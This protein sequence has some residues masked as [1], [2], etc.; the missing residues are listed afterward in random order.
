[1]VP[2]SMIPE[3]LLVTGAVVARVVGRVGHVDNRAPGRFVGA[4]EGVL[5]TQPYP[6]DDH[7]ANADRAHSYQG[8]GS[9]RLFR[10]PTPE[11]AKDVLLTVTSVGQN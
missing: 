6:A 9:C 8:T 1:M 7:D 10:L 4:G 5:P 11:G 2:L 3:L